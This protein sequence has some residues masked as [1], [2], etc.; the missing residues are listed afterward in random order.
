MGIK[1]DGLEVEAP[2]EHHQG[3]GAEAE[4]TVTTGTGAIRV[5]GAEVVRYR[6]AQKYLILFPDGMASLTYYRLL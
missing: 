5:V 6:E 4:E 1:A 2:P 3:A